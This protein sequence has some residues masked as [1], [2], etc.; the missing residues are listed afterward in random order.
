MIFWVVIVLLVVMLAVE[1]RPL[2][3]GW[4]QCDAVKPCV[5]PSSTV[6]APSI[7]YPRG[8]AW[9]EDTADFIDRVLRKAWGPHPP[10]VDLYLR[11]GCGAEEELR[12]FFMT[13]DLFWPR[14]LGSVVLVLD[15]GD[16]ALPGKLPLLS[17]HNVRVYYEHVPCVLPGRI[18]NQ[19]SY[20]TLDYYSPNAEYVVT[21]DSD[22]AFHTP[23]TPEL[24]FNSEG[25]LIFPTSKVFQAREWDLDQRYFTGID[26]LPRYGQAMVTQPVNFRVDTFHKFRSWTKAKFGETY[27][28]RLLAWYKAKGS[29][30]WYAW[31][32]QLAVFI[33]HERVPGYD[34]HVLEE[35]KD[36][37]FRYNVHVTYEGLGSYGY[38][39]TV[40]LAINEGLCLWF[41]PSVFPSC[42]SITDKLVRRYMY[43]YAGYTMNPLCSRTDLEQDLQ[44]RKERMRALINQKLP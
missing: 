2:P 27:A 5:P 35:R 32:N 31:M 40:S 19:Y 1:G 44:A 10:T 26:M 37:Y 6:A 30:G 9:G 39:G 33:A 7:E 20:L 4:S 43:E 29:P 41:G 42:D 12:Y 28:N 18:F 24:I 23:V 36:L 17:K 15:V 25:L 21:I 34:V 13:V 16:E 22:C 3:P 11:A 8:T 38:R 14:F